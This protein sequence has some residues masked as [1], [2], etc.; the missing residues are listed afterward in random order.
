MNDSS[1]TVNLF[2]KITNQIVTFFLLTIA[3]ETSLILKNW[4]TKDE[5]SKEKSSKDTFLY[6]RWDI[7][8]EI[9]LHVLCDAVKLE[10]NTCHV[11]KLTGYCG[12]KKKTF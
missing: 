12:K 3:P 11:K 5:S 6:V 10:L 8:R 7:G 2:C 4:E 1:Q 9:S